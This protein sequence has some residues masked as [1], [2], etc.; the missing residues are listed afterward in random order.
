[1][2]PQHLLVHICVQQTWREH[3]C[4]LKAVKN[5][6]GG[7]GCCKPVHI[8]QPIPL[9]NPA[10]GR[11]STGPA[12]SMDKDFHCASFLPPFRG[13]HTHFVPGNGAAR[14]H[15]CALN[16]A[17]NGISSCS[18]LGESQKV[19]SALP[20]APSSSNTK[21]WEGGGIPP[22]HSMEP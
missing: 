16:A 22:Q 13:W 21:P 5:R 1:M 20:P 15:T 10:A 9:S 17:H 14:L 11:L 6:Q 8:C 2:S 3:V 19:L 18:L 7:Q 4:V 12:K